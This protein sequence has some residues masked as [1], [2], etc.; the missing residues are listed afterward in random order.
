MSYTVSNLKTEIAGMIHGTTVNK[1]VSINALIYRAARQLLSDADLQE[2]K[3]ITPLASAI[4]SNVY[5]Y[6]IPTDLKGNK[7]IDIYKQ[8]NVDPSQSFNQDYAKQFNQNKTSLQNQFNIQ[9]NSGTKT[10]RIQDSDIPVGTVVNSVDSVT[11]NGTWAVGGTASSLA[12]D[13]VNYVAGGSSLKFN[14]TTGAA[15]IQN[16]TMTAQDLSDFTNQGHFFV[17]VYMPTASQFTNVKLQ[18]GSSTSDYYEQTVTTNQQ[19]NAFIDGWN[20]LDFAWSGSS[21]TGSPVDTAIDYLRVTCTVTASQTAVKVN[22]VVCQLGTIMNIMYYSKYLF[23]NASSG[24]W[25]ETILDD[26]DIINLDTDSYNLLVYQCGI[27][28]AQQL[29]GSDSGFDASYF[30][31]NYAQALGRYRNMY[32][33]EV[34]KPQQLYYATKRPGYTK[35][36]NW[37]TY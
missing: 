20:L 9:F 25:Q 7:I 12:E 5:D 8:V 30:I 1:V 6:A 10:I 3:R 24:T 15:Y 27:Q 33:S 28:L 18:W 26:S 37:R 19:G 34:Q 23:R 14:A 13:N 29:Q 31:S 36:I 35:Y 11:G 17:W 2:T 4:Y 16:S 22:N 32:K 21:T